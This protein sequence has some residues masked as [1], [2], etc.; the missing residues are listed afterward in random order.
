MGRKWAACGVGSEGAGPTLSTD[1]QWAAADATAMSSRRRIQANF[2]M[3]T[4]G[5]ETYNAEVPAD[6][7]YPFLYSTVE[8]TVTDT[9]AAVRSRAGGARIGE[10]AHAHTPVHV[11]WVARCRTGKTRSA[12]SSAWSRSSSSRASVSASP[13]SSLPSWPT[14]AAAATPTTKQSTRVARLAPSCTTIR[15]KTSSLS[16]CFFFFGPFC[17]ISGLRAGKRAP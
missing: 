13:S 5:F 1:A 15:H 8:S 6:V 17:N 16:P 12:A 7:F 9:Q 14:A 11:E 3:P 10:R 2:Y 4:D